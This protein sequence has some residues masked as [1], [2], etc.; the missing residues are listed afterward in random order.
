ML[1]R[2]RGTWRWASTEWS[3]LWK[4]GCYKLTAKQTAWLSL[5]FSRNLCA[6]FWGSSFPGLMLSEV[7]FARPTVSFDMRSGGAKSHSTAL[8]HFWSLLAFFLPWLEE[9][10]NCSHTLLV[11]VGCF[12]PWL[13]FVFVCCVSPS[14]AEDWDVA[15]P[16]L[17]PLS[18][19]VLVRSAALHWL[20]AHHSKGISMKQKLNMWFF[21]VQMWTKKPGVQGGQRGG[22]AVCGFSRNEASAV[23]GA[24]DHVYP[25]GARLLG[26]GGA[27]GGLQ[28]WVSSKVIRYSW[29]DAT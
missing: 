1:V 21:C 10:F 24:D 9:S 8:A 29:A 26:A 6:Q 16:P 19:R 12:C 22:S 27:W 18:W 25:P 7:P 28:I 15:L 2:G 20:C 11:F 13:E 17:Q 3:S 14:R 4:H 5:A 23:R